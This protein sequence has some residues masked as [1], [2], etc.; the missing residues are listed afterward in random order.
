MLVSFL[1]GTAGL[2][3]SANSLLETPAFADMQARDFA[4]D[5]ALRFADL[6][7]RA[8]DLNSAIAA[9]EQ[10]LIRHPDDD[11][12]RQR[13]AGFYRDIGNAD[14]ARHHDDTGAPEQ[15]RTRVW[16][17]AS[18]GA[19]YD[20]NPTAAEHNPNSR[21]FDALDGSFL[22]V[23]AQDREPDPVATFSLDL[24]ATHRLSETALLTAEFQAEGERYKTLREL[25]N[26][27]AR[28]AIGPWLGPGKTGPGEIFFRPFLT[29]SAGTLDGQPYH[30]GIGGGAQLRF[31]LGD[32]LAGH[33]SLS[34]VR[35]DYN[36]D[37]RDGLQV[38][39]FSNVAVSAAT[40]LAGRGPLD[41]GWGFG[42]QLGAIDADAETES[43]L[44]LGFNADV[45]VPIPP[46]AH[47]LGVP[48]TLG[49]GGT[50]DHFAYLSVDPVVDP[51]QRRDDVWIGGAG[52]L[53]IGL[54]KKL[55]LTIGA[56]YVRRFSNIAAFDSE[57]LR[58]HYEIGY[59][60]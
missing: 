38:N 10:A 40:G 44:F 15:P 59:R 35:T 39:R 37:L 17:R 6:A 50:V 3:A 60:F 8:G 20:T 53:E 27:S 24:S 16:G 54:T 41:S 48:V 4:P 52:S 18:I 45:S 13:V 7:E 12:L 42:V 32:E 58:I 2:E 47:R 56:D 31:G 28:I 21:I 25:D 22:T 43:Y 55:D 9:L 57:N 29:L 30:S 11:R 1:A 19:G 46:L 33:A 26:I 51:T 5:A 49:L 23:L 36:A 14:M 34:I